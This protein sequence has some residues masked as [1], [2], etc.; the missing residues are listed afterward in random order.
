MNVLTV[1]EIDRQLASR[2]KEV[3][4]LSTTLVERGKTR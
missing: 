3:A 2:T 1:D 4:E